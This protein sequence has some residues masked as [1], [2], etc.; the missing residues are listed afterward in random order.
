MDRLRPGRA[1]SVY[2][3]SLLLMVSALLSG[4]LGL[5]RNKLIAQIFGAGPAVD[6]YNAAF[7]LPDVIYYL[8]IGGVASTTFVK[9]LST[10]ESNGTLEEGDRA[11]S[12]IL[13][14]VGVGL[15]I[16]IAAG[17]LLAP[18]YVHYKFH[19]F[20]G[21]PQ[22][23]AMCVYMTR[24][25]LPNQLLLLAGGVFG[26]RL[27]LRKIFIYQ[28]MQ[29]LLYNGGIIAGAL[30]FGRWL[31]IYS[32]AVGAA[33]GALFGF[34]LINYVGARR[35]GMRWTPT[36]DLRHPTLREWLRLSLPLILGQSIVTLDPIIRSYF[37]ANITGG[38]SLMKYS[39]D[40]FAAP[41]GI[42]GPAAGLASLP[43]FASLWSGGDIAR[44]STAVNRS[45]SRLLAVSLLLTSW[46]V[47]LAG[48]I[49]N[50]ALS[51]GR[52]RGH[53]AT[54]AVQLFIL[55]C[56]SLVFW[57]SQNLYARAF[58]AAGNT[59]TPMLSGTVV[60]VLSL[61]VYALLFR[62]Y[63]IAG[64]VVAS[65]IAIAAHMLALAVLLHRK[66]MVSVAELEWPEL[67][68]ALLAAAASG[69]GIVL[70][71]RV[72]PLGVT[73]FDNV[74]RLLLG[75]AIGLAIALGVLIATGSALPRAVLRKG[76]A[77]R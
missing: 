65:D 71:L 7:E 57:T 75:S 58:Y 31:G 60:T 45:V 32:L 26:S 3:A 12:N 10:Y 2:S 73:H 18:L 15:L 69:I 36:F 64:L 21:S 55:F 50:V 72:L 27:L 16:A 17:E 47:A 29:P 52:F 11:L 54:G 33:G 74:L 34:F 49:I 13:N 42:V 62:G 35:I 39:R 44:F 5:V 1:Q 19:D 9:L 40:L 6:A 25:L 66:R 76:N 51:G 70:I 63:G 41:M 30:V 68:R 22:T 28:A 53:D 77:S 46:M 61:P 8:L 56:L 67:G 48:P 37:A 38:I 14:V 43:F 23:A 4:L 59:L 24:I 20:H